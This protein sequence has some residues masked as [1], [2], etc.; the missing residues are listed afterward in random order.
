M[1]RNRTARVLARGAA[2]L[3]LT[4]GSVAAVGATPASARA[5]G[6]GAYSTSTTT[7]YALCTNGTGIG[8]D[9]YRVQLTCRHQGSNYTANGPWVLPTQRSYKT[10]PYGT[11]FAKA[12]DHA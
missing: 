8:S 6:C 11:I 7:A 3:A 5:F 10:C 1:L 9:S 4:A 12:V 2:V